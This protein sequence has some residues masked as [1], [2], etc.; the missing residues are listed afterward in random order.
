MN[1][2]WGLWISQIRAQ[3]LSRASLGSPKRIRGFA[4][5]RNIGRTSMFSYQPLDLIWRAEI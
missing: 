1:L 3:S 5:A 4:Y 2:G